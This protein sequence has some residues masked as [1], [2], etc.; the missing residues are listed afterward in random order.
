MPAQRR[1]QE[2][3]LGGRELHARRQAALRDGDVAGGELAG[4]LVHVAG[5]LDALGRRHRAGSMRGPHTTT[6][7]S[8]GTFARAS[9]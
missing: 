5:E 6:M 1:V 7:R 4:Q 9:G 3:R 2:R 8:S